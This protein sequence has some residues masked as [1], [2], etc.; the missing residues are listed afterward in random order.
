MSPENWYKLIFILLFIKYEKEHR[1]KIWA[2]F[3]D[4]PLNLDPNQFELSTKK[5]I[6]IAREYFARKRIARHLR[7]CISNPDYLVCQRR[8]I[9]EFQELI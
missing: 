5:K 4:G 9:R 8:L 3:F 2:A 7:E 6:E 1:Q